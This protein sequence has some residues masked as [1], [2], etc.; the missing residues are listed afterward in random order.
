MKKRH[1]QKLILLAA[2]LFFL[3]NVPFVALFDKELH[4]LG[5][6]LFYAFIFLCWLGGIIISYI[7]LKKFYE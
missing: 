3:W 6:P 4:V 5:F 7:I 1:Q 2:V